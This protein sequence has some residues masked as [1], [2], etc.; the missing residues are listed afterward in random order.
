MERLQEGVSDDSGLNGML[1]LNVLSMPTSL[2]VK[3]LRANSIRERPEVRYAFIY[4]HRLLWPALG[5]L[6]KGESHAP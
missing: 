6:V 4:R 2:E 3:S 1:A 5:F